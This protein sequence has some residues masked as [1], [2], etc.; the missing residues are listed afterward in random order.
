MAFREGSDTRIRYGRVLGLLF[1][2]AGFSVIG[3]AWNG[4]ASVACVDCQFPY[5]ISGGATGI[6]LIVLGSTLLVVSALRAERMH[7]QATLEDARGA[8]PAAAGTAEVS[9]SRTGASSNGS[10]VI[11][12]STYHRPDCRLVKGK[13]DLERTSVAEAAASGLSACRV[14][15]PATA[16]AASASK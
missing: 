11:G 9:G 13:A 5:L 12:R 16:D 15:S 1:L 14:C 4:A 3:V 2:A 6:G 10:V 8:V 7:L